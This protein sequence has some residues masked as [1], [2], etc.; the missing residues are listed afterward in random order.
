SFVA[1]VGTS[2]S[3]KST[4]L[5]MINRLVEP[6][7]GTISIDG[8]AVG[9]AEL[10]ELRRGIGYV[11]QNIGLFPHMTVAENIGI[12]LW[13]AGEQGRRPRVAQAGHVVYQARRVP[14]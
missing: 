6:S 5:K 9:Q 13:L 4:L 12:A 14:G 11:F 7:A 10:H 2:G 3:G 1:L 8:E